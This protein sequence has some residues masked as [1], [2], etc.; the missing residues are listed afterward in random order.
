MRAFM[1]GM[2]YA[3]FGFTNLLSVNLHLPFSHIPSSSHPSCGFYYFL[4]KSAII[5]PLFLL[6]LFLSKRYRMRQRNIPVN[7]HLFAENYYEKY[8][9]IERQ[10]EEE[11]REIN[12]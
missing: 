10:I 5:C 3:A 11:E 12:H 9:N 7:F 2:W 1:I 6:F 8:I 4:T